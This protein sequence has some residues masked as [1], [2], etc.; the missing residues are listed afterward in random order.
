MPERAVDTTRNPEA[1][2]VAER[3]AEVASILARGLVRS[4]RLARLRTSFAAQ[5]VS[6][7]GETGLDLPGDLPLSVAQRPGG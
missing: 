4:A 3:R 7:V 6:E 1:M 5:K 2:T